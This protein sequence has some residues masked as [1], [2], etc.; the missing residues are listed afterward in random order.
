MDDNDRDVWLI[1]ETVV[2]WVFLEIVAALAVAVAIVWWTFPKKP[3]AVPPKD[4][5]ARPG[6]SARSMQDARERSA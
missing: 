5:D 6:A 4:G 3:K 2:F 1:E